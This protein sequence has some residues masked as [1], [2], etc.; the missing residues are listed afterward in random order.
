MQNFATENTTKSDIAIAG[1]GI[2]GLTLA[3]A[4]QSTLK[5]G[6]KVAVIDPSLSA[7]KTRTSG[8]ASAIAAGPRQMLEA[9][10]VWQQLKDAQPILKMVVTDSRLHDPVRP[11]F[12]TFDSPAP[13]A[14][15]AHMVMN[16]ELRDVLLQ[17][18]RDEGV[19]L[20]AQSVRNFTTQADC[21]E[22]DCP[23][24]RHFAR[25]L[26]AADGAQSRLRDLA[27]IQVT[28][29]AYDQTGIVAT[30]EHERPHQG[31]AEEHFMAD[32][33]FAILPLTGNCSSIVWSDT[34]TH[35][36]AMM[37]LDDEDFQAEL[38]QRFTLR[39]GALK[40][41]DR[42]KLFPLNL[43]WARRYYAPRFALLGDAA[44]VIHPIAGQGLNL[45]MKDV[46]CLAELIVE[47]MRLGLDPGAS[48]ILEAYQ[49]AR[50]FDA[51]SMGTACDLIYR[52]F[53]NDFLPLRLIRD[54]GLG[55]VDKLPPLKKMFIREASGFMGKIPPLLRGEK[56]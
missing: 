46:A 55:L 24:Q 5:G 20:I 30:I 41:R 50:R 3:L 34:R 40:L 16:D 29:H 27:R 17:R 36:S 13:D 56:L 31:R 7:A 47:Q 35:A 54:L 22:L 23:D 33:P 44:H 8:R 32:G 21:V 6:I 2:A 45:G 15:F 28:R 52:M 25:L 4:L 38:E 19:T 48:D 37:E 10:D 42:P 43:L 11:V 14:P 9:L 51:V 39:L 26:I 12:L 18:C 49:Q 1:A 53:S